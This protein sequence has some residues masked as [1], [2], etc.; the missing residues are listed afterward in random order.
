MVR[1]SSDSLRTLE[2]FR[3]RLRQGQH[4]GAPSGLVNYCGYLIWTQAIYTYNNNIRHIPFWVLC[5]WYPNWYGR[6][7]YSFA[8]V[9][10][11]LA[12]F[13]FQSN[14]NVCPIKRT[15]T[16]KPLTIGLL[17][18]RVSP[19]KPDRKNSIWFCSFRTGH[20]AVCGS[21]LPKIQCSLINSIGYMRR[22]REPLSHR[23]ST[24]Q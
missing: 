1:P 17:S 16:E 22:G 9:Q 4:N 24:I 12:P 13:N 21:C 14:P 18:A 6:W 10:R 11:R 5:N 19:T 2:H 7:M 8:R 20:W 23:F 3:K 15:S